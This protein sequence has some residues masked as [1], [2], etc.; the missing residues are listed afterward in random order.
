VAVSGV[1]ARF[2]LVFGFWLGHYFFAWCA[3][4]AL[5]L[6]VVL[7]VPLVVI[8][9]ARI[10]EIATIAFGHRPQ[11]LLKA[12]VAATDGF[13]PK[14]SIHVPAHPD[15]PHLLHPPL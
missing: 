6:G 15:P 5:T 3:A 12:A 13:A 4:F 8:A 14:V 1:G 11:R 9:L 10:E 2:A 7:L